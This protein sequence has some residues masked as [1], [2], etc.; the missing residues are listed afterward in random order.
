[1]LRFTPVEVTTVETAHKHNVRKVRKNTK[2]FWFTNTTATSGSGSRTPRSA[3]VITSPAPPEASGEAKLLLMLN[4]RSNGLQEKTRTPEDVAAT[5]CVPS[6]LNAT[7]TSGS[8]ATT[9][10]DDMIVVVEIQ[11]Q[12]DDVQQEQNRARIQVY[13]HTRRTV[14][15]HEEFD[16]VT[17]RI[18]PGLAY[19]SPYY[20]G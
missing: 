6:L 20:Y 15:V 5:R 13:T 4:T 10:E 18:E 8:A 1:M 3:E 9:M 2:S 17:N 16:A 14:R 19:Y 11:Q 12:L 7:C